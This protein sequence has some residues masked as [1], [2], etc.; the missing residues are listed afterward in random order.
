MNY[1]STKFL[2][3]NNL[4]LDCFYF[5]SSSGDRQVHFDNVTKAKLYS[6]GGHPEISLPKLQDLEVGFDG[7]YP[8]ILIHFLEQHPHLTR[9]HLKTVYREIEYE[10]L[11]SI[12]SALPNLE[13]LS[14]SNKRPYHFGSN[15]SIILLE[16]YPKLMKF[17]ADLLDAEDK[18]EICEK[19]AAHGTL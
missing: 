7:W 9:L 18:K 8:N 1:A 16:E 15:I 6:I 4:V 17:N 10:N 13:E 5:C 11:K 2:N 12:S 3:V 14:I 19:L